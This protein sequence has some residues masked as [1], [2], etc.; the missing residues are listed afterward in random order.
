M[1]FFSFINDFLYETKFGPMVKFLKKK[2]F[3][4]FK[5]TWIRIYEEMHI[6]RIGAWM[7]NEIFVVFNFTTLT[8]SEWKPIIWFDTAFLFVNIVSFTFGIKFTLNAY[9]VEVILWW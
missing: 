6:L 5:F 2:L 8:I 4:Y 9:S 3:C 1:I 7:E